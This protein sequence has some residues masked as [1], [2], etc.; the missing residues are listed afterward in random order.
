MSGTGKIEYSKRSQSR[1]RQRNEHR[2]CFGA[3]SAKNQSIQ[4]IPDVFEEERPGGT[5]ERKHFAIS[6]HFVARSGIRRYQEK[7]EQRGKHYHGNGRGSA[8]P[9][10]TALNYEGEGAQH[11]SHHNHGVQTDK[12]A[13]EKIFDGHFL[14]TVVVGI[15]NHESGKNKEKVDSQVA[16]IEPLVERA[17]SESLE[18]VVKNDHDGSYTA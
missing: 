5:V 8:V 3:H 2:K 14:P 13:F 6:T 12:P 15:T 9:F 1:T 4:N 7:T 11:K 10:F 16:M 18:Y 17:G